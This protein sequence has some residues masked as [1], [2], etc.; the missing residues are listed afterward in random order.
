MKI[1]RAVVGVLV[2]AVSGLSLSGCG[3]GASGSKAKHDGGKD[4]GHD[5]AVVE[6]AAVFDVG[7]E[8]G[9]GGAGGPDT[10][11]IDGGGTGGTASGGTGG[12]TVSSDLDGST[13]AAAIGTGGTGGSTVDGA[14][15]DDGA[16]DMAG[17]GAGGNGSGGSGG[18]GS[19]GGGQSGQGGAADAPLGSDVGTVTFDGASAGIDGVPVDLAALDIEPLL[20]QSGVEAAEEVGDTAADTASAVLAAHAGPDR[21]I[22]AGSSIRVGAPASGGTPGYAYAWSSNPSCSGCVDDASAAQPVV[23]PGATTTF[24][25]TVTDATSAQASDAMTVTVIGG[26]TPVANAG[27]DLGGDPGAATQIG[28][29]AQAGHT[30]VWTCDR[31]DCG[32]SDVGAA[33]P[34]VRPTLSTQYTVTATSPEG[35]M[36]SDRMVV[37]V[38]LPYSSSPAD[39]E[40][41]YPMNAD[42]LVHF[43]APVLTASLAGGNVKLVEAGSGTPV[44]FST[45]YDAASRTLAIVPTGANYDGTI[46]DYT[47]V[48]VGGDTGIRSDDPLRPQLLPTDQLIDFTVANTTDTSAP[49][50]VFRSPDQGTTGVALNTA[51][52]VGFSEMLDPVTVT[53]GHVYLTSSAGT[54]A[55]AV[56][57]AADSQTVTLK[58]A[59]NLAGSTVYTV[60]VIG[61]ADPAGNAISGTTWTFTTGP[62]PD[63]TPPTVTA[64]SPTQAASG[65]TV[66]TTVVLTFSEMIDQTT[67]AAGFSLARAA[68]TIAGSMAYDAAAKRATFTPSTL[69]DGLTVYTVT[70]KGVRDLAGNAMAAPFTSTFTTG[71]VLF[72]DAFESGT[73]KWTLDTPWA[74]TTKTFKSASHSLTDSPGGLYVTSINVSATSATFDASVV[75]SV[76][77]RFWLRGRTQSNQDRLYV[78]YSR[79]GGAWTQLGSYSGNMGWQQRSLPLTLASGTTTL[80]IRFRLT[81]N[82]TKQYDGVYIDDVVV[83]SP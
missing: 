17:A 60:H 23:T 73:G 29:P 79:N 59:A 65:V 72:A 6:V 82:N 64:I 14:F 54:V 50:I 39:G 53:T 57:S 25:V 34:V 52:V 21:T 69:L 58:P 83:Q 66:A 81:S 3:C 4:G 44:T 51:V 31:A 74:L 20:D 22:C 28:T 68:G 16:P 5:G 35:C 76:T 46:A 63:T 78:E 43:G 61:I 42:L 8:R 15:E 45:S 55:A 27:P 30:Y 33:Q 10:A 40:T 75:P 18:G 7:S 24:T 9:A 77:V 38:N 19:G 41:A 70:V 48:L 62:T 56:A 80:Q 36:Q 47:L 13:D 32:I 49:T 1:C 2:A 67:L 37:W 26:T 11:G 12:T 71:G